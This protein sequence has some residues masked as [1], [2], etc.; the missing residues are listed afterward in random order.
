MDSGI[1]INH[2][3]FRDPD[4]GQSR[5]RFG[6]TTAVGEDPSNELDELGHGTHVAGVAAGLSVGVAKRAEVVAVKILGKTKKGKWSAVLKALAFIGEDYRKSR[7]K[8]ISGA[9]VNMSL[10]GSI[11]QP[12]NNAVI[13]L[14]KLGISVVV[15]SGNFI[16]EDA[17][18]R[19]PGC[20]S[21]AIKV[22]S[23]G[24]DDGVSPFSALGSC[25]DIFAPGESINSAW[26]GPGNDSYRTMTGTSM[27]APHI[28][29]IIAL[30]NS[31]AGQLDAASM[32]HLLLNIST[33]STLYNYEPLREGTPNQLAYNRIDNLEWL[34]SA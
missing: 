26:K 24:V 5:A 7:A 17:C 19:T 15:A 9:V 34:F 23:S 4:T 3:E 31:Q 27:A 28:S 8:G 20:V 25:V 6:I 11:S 21:A 22:A 30:L 18:A 2:T 14:T 16:G 10:E 13:A 32:K 1:N 33:K 29:G 12:V